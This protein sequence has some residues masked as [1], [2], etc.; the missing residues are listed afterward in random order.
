MKTYNVYFSGSYGYNIK[1]EAENKGEAKE[2][3]NQIHNSITSEEIDEMLYYDE[4]EISFVQE[5]NE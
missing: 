1:I 4:L 5:V 3:A 2:K